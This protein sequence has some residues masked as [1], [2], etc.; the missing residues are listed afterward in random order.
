MT[1]MTANLLSGSRHGISL[2]PSG[3]KLEKASIVSEIWR[4]DANMYIDYIVDMGILRVD[5]LDGSD[6]RGVDR[7]GKSDPYAVFTLN[8][9]RV[10]KSQIIKK[11]LAPQWNED[12]LCNVVSPIHL[13]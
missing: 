5:L 12:F 3:L 9:D 2:F 7:S 10:Y 11:T 8:G 6:I 1:T 13:F 4:L